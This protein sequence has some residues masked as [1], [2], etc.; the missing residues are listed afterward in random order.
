MA[1]GRETKTIAENRRA[2]HD[3]HL[4]ERLEAGIQLT[5]TEVKSLREGGATLQRAFADVRDGEVY[6][7]GAHIGEYAQGNMQNHEPDRDR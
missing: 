1:R 7:V 6:L 3:Y 4:L 2:R 5:G